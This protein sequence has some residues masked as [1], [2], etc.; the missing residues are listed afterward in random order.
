[1]ALNN[2]AICLGQI[3]THHIYYNISS[4]E[5]FINVKAGKQIK[6]HSTYLTLSKTIM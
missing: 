4:Q 5:L 1:M 3:I 6:Y 2:I